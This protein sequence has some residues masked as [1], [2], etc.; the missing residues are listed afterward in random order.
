MSFLSN[1]IYSKLMQTSTNIMDKDQLT[2]LYVKEIVDGMDLN[3]CLALLEDYMV[4]TYSKYSYE[5]VKEE[6]N[7]Y[8]PHLLDEEA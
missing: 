7:E 4:E 3:D 8:Y 5:E 1:F 2:K 6:V